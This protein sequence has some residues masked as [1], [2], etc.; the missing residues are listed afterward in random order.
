MKIFAL[1]YHRLYG[2]VVEQIKMQLLPY[3]TY[4]E[5]SSNSIWS[6]FF[7][8]WSNESLHAVN[9]YMVNLLQP[10]KLCGQTDKA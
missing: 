2:S 3:S 5:K 9:H 4:R 8:K 1:A 10:A 6:K 7:V